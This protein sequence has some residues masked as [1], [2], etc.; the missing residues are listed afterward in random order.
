MTCAFSIFVV[1]HIHEKME[2]GDQQSLTEWKA[3]REAQAAED[4]RLKRMAEAVKVLLECV[5]EDPERDGLLD[6][7]MRMAKAW[8]FFTKGYSET[9]EEVVGGALF[10]D[11]E[12]SDG[13]VIMRDIDVW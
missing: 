5:G 13:M 7:P 4:I 6:T 11:E 1:I 10:K 12:S 8:R 2:E 9:L 3:A